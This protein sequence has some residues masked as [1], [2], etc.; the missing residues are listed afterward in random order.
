VADTELCD[1]PQ[2]LIDDLKTPE[3][4]DANDASTALEL[5][6][7]EDDCYVGGVTDSGDSSEPL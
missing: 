5:F 4:E 2:G 3:P 1:L 7:Q 6:E